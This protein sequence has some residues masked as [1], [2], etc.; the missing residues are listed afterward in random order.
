MDRYIPYAI[1]AGVIALASF[2]LAQTLKKSTFELDIV[3]LILPWLGRLTTPTSP[4][5]L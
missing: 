3:L 5:Q 2:F 4:P 1:T